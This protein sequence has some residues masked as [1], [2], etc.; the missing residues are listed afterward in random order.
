MS[1]VKEEATKLIDGLPEQ[2]TWDNLMYALYVKQRLQKALE[3]TAAG[4]VIPHETAKK[5]LTS[6]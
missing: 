4:K 6:Q 1:V 3:E 5:E 2:A